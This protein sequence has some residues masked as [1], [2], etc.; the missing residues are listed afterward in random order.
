MPRQLHRP[1]A[2]SQWWQDA[3]IYQIYP[4]SFA[5]SGGPIG[6]L[7]AIT[8]RL[9][10]VA[11]LGADAVWLSPFY[12]SP[13]HDA[14][15][16]VADY[17]N[18]DPRLG[19]LEDADALIARTH[20]LGMRII[21]DLVP[22]HTSDEHV[23]FREALS[24]GPD[25]P[26]RERYWF[27]EAST[28]APPNDWTS[29]FGSIAWTRVRERDDAP[30]SPWQDDPQWYLHLFDSSQ[31]DLNW[32]NPAVHAEFRD[33]LRFWLDRGVDGFRID[34][35]HGLAKD[36]ELPDWQYH[37]TMVE[38]SDADAAS[39]PPPPMWDRDGVHDIYREWRTVLDE[40]G[41][42]RMLVAEAWVSPGDRLAQYVRSDEMSQC[43]NF[44][45]LS[46]QWKRD[47]LRA[48]I[49]SSLRA[50]DAVGAPTTWVLSN[51]DVVRAA[52]RLGLSHT[53]KGPNG[54]RATD[55]QPDPE[56]G[57]RR[58][59]AAHLLMAGLPGSCYLYQGE[60]L[61]LPEHTALPDDVREDP[62]YFRTKGVEAGRDGCRVPLPWRAQAPAFGFS[63]DGQSWLPQPPEW[64][65]FA[66]DAQE[67]ST[68]STLNFFRRMYALRSELAL[69][70]GGLED[71]S[72]AFPGALAYLN[73]AP[74]DAERGDIL[75]LT[76][77]DTDV[78]I[79]EDWRVL[80][81]SAAPGSAESTTWL[82]RA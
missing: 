75:I 11:S 32:D 21:I 5:S 69:G 63:P 70:H 38:G 3:V 22:N 54:I 66:V 61:G 25:S 59:L 20:E 29:I 68:S 44:D 65:A 35:A 71:V 18:I 7:P 26:E 28:D 78:S 76:T 17:R 67:A 82:A 8:A 30:G 19:T 74:A 39:V 31:P 12:P 46:S 45:F 14:G 6:D 16:D 33:V 56:L 2:P 24:A 10:Y 41:P 58:A 79:P 52:S 80:L 55:E 40:Y 64:A 43:F 13:Q 47:D 9:E 53:G 36:P 15:Y 62:A 51:H 42:D 50:M 27:R 4:R 48:V 23:W 73:T 72:D 81:A 77:F 57:A 1:T 37:W 34:V 49:A 60:E